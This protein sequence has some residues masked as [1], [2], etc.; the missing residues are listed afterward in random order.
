MINVLSLEICLHFSFSLWLMANSDPQSLS[1]CWGKSCLMVLMSSMAALIT[2]QPH[3]WP[4][5]GLFCQQSYIG[6]HIK[7]YSRFRLKYPHQC[8]SAW[9]SR[10]G[11]VNDVWKGFAL[12]SRLG[13]SWLEYMVPIKDRQ[14]WANWSCKILIA[15]LIAPSS[16]SR[17]AA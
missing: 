12:L 11:R 13:C 4:G 3:Q 1:W 10:V 9:C 14:G 2:G 6:S 17:Q 5:S 15:P 7:R 16:C 8:L